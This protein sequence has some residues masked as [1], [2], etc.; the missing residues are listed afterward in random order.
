MWC[1]PVRSGRET[2]MQYFLCLSGTGAVSIKNALRHDT[3]KLDSPVPKTAGS[4]FSY[5]DQEL[6]ALVRFVWQHILE[7][8]PTPTDPTLIR[9]TS[10]SLPSRP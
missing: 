1:I 10:S 7:E 9:T 8:T 6:S 2:S 4:T 5:F 3:R